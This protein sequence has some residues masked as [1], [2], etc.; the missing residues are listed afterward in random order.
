[1]VNIILPSGGITV[2]SGI[3]VTVVDTL[4]VF[5]GGTALAAVI[6][7]GVIAVTSGGSTQDTQIDAGGEYVYSGGVVNGTTVY[8]GGEYVYSGGT[9]T[10]VNLDGG[11]EYLFGGTASSTTVASGTLSVYAGGIADGAK[12]TNGQMTVGSGGYSSETQITNAS[13]EVVGSGGIATATTLSYHG[14]QYINAGG[15]A[16]GTTITSGG[17]ELVYGTASNTTIEPGGL[18]FVVSGGSTV[19]PDGQIDLT[20]GASLGLTTLP[21][22]DDGTADLLAGPEGYF[23][24]I[25]VGGTNF[26]QPVA[27]Q[28]GAYYHIYPNEG[29][30]GIVIVA[31]DTPCYCRGTRIL[32]ERGEVAVEDLQIGDHVI[33]ASCALRPI[34]WIGTRSYAGRFAAH[35]RD[36]LPVLIR[37]GALEDNVPKRDLMVS[38]LH[39]M[40]L[41][42]AL[43]PAACLVNGNSIIQLEVVEQVDYFHIELDSHDVILAE[44]ALSE[45][46]VNDDSRGMFHN[47]ASYHAMYPDAEPQP[48]RYCAAR[49]EGGEEL[50]MIHQR[51]QARARIAVSCSADMSQVSDSPRH[52]AA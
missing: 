32:T 2:E 7:G 37:A 15:Q 52:R 23:I 45:T 46:F 21:Y 40:Y 26:Q 11:T 33:T 29:G 17:E 38:P 13:Q 51:L 6:E 3:T 1:M 12:L 27:Y 8:A 41:D 5:S 31:D 39:A 14:D 4:Q 28:Y 49:L 25:N 10:D 47:A 19:D 36:V 16:V 43:V 35:N 30:P 9:T 20:L 18:E 48:A 44:G 24:D 22:A 34:R 50:Q 42:G